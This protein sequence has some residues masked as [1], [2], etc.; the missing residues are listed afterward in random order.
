[1]NIIQ[2]YIILSVLCVTH[3]SELLLHGIG[4]MKEF[5]STSRWPPALSFRVI[6]SLL[7]N[8]LDLS[9]DGS[10]VQSCCSVR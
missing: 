9:R 7:V 10:V 2:P 8:E 4:N 6:G 5:F 1:M 3:T